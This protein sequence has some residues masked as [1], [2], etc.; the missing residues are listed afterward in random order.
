[1]ECK[2]TQCVWFI[3]HNHAWEPC[4]VCQ[5]VSKD[6]QNHDH[7]NA[8]FFVCKFNCFL[9]REYVSFPKLSF[10]GYHEK[11]FFLSNNTE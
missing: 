4:Y 8:F 6:R 2:S 9:A 3:P 5:I 1:M 10:W 7:V 11:F